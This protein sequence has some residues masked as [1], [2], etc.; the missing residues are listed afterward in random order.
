MKF[1]Y[2]RA[3]Q[4]MLRT[5]RSLE[6]YCATL[7]GRW[8]F[9]CFSILMGH[10]WNEIDIE[11]PKYSGKNLSQCHFVHHKSHMDRR[12]R[13]CDVEELDDDHLPCVCFSVHS[14][15]ECGSLILSLYIKLYH[16]IRMIIKLLITRRD[17]YEKPVVTQPV[18]KFPAVCGA[19]NVKN[20]SE[21]GE[22]YGSYCWTNVW[23]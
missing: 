18:S 16:R 10:R 3:P 22:L 2:W 23:S 1:F 4:Q 12:L 17:F 15:H 20:R 8:S 9:F 6:A 19:R 14:V 7:W 21:S 5:H 11:K 13:M